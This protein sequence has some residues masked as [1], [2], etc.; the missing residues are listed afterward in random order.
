MGAAD[1]KLVHGGQDRRGIIV[2]GRAV[3]GGVAVAVARIVERD[4]ATSTA[5]MVELWPPHGF[6]GTDPVEEDE[7]G[8]ITTAR[9]LVADGVAVTRRN[10]GHKHTLAAGHPPR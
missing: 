3:G 8:R 7:G 1:A 2:A 5:E 4:R 10:P 6:V 9:L